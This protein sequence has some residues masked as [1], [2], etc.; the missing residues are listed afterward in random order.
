MTSNYAKWYHPYTPDERYQKRA[1]Y[2]CM[3]FAIHQSLKIYSGGLGYLAGSHLRS[4]FE[5]KQ[6]MIAIG[7]LWSYGY[8]DQTRDENGLMKPAFTRKDYAFLEDTGIKVTISVN[9]HPVHVKVYCLP[10]HVFNTAPLYLLSTDIPENDA[11]SRTI[12]QRLYDGNTLTRM[13]QMI[14]LGVGGAKVIEA[15]GGTDIYHMNESHALPLL[16]YMY[17]KYGSV[18]EVK[19]R[20]VFTT[21]TPEK[22]GN[23][24]HNIHDLNKL[25]FFGNVPLE[26]AKRI[27]G[28]EGDMFGHTPAALRLAKISNGVSQLHAVVSKEMWSSYEGISDIIGITNAQNFQYWADKDLYAAMEENNDGL[29]LHLKRQKKKELFKVIADQCGKLFDEN[30]LTIVW[31]RRFAGYKRADLLLTDLDRLDKFLNNIDKPVQLVFAGKPYPLDQAAISIFN[32]LIE[33]SRDKKNVAVV[34]GYELDLSRKLKDAGD[35]W[36]NTPRMTR[37]ASGTSGMTAAMN[38]SISVSLPDGW[39]P[40]FAKHGVNCFIS[41]ATDHHLPIDKQ[42]EIDYENI[43]SILENEVVTTYYDNPSQWAALMKNAMRDV[44][45]AFESGRMAHEYYERMYNF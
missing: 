20:Y 35:V 13:A 19:K 3:E 17:E 29:L 2:F 4:A 5:L 39:I 32:L 36:L 30:A 31:A 26:E 14:V 41:D 24:E 44:T 27:T 42:D 34:L 9:H 12:T 18:E 21:H 8:Y 25:S 10:S 40:E 23:E 7:M 45:P 6:N 37:E 22:A 15:L 38:G 43:M 1:A 16:F 28:T 33:Y 11:L